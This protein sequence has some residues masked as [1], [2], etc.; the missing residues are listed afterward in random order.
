MRLQ[1]LANHFSEPWDVVARFLGSLGSQVAVD[2]DDV[3]VIICTDGADHELPRETLSS[4]GIPVRYEVLE[5]AGV[6]RTRNALMDMSSAD[7]VM[8]CD[9]DDCMHSTLGL[10]RMMKAM[11][12]VGTDII[13]A[14]YDVESHDDGV[15][16]YRTERRDTTHVFSKAFRRSYLVENGIRFPDEMP[17]SGDMYFLWLAF[18]LG[19]T[20]AWIGD[21]FYVWKDNPDSI[22]RRSPWH[23]VESYG[24]LLRNYQLLHDE[25]GR[26]GRSDL[27][28]T[29]VAAVFAMMY[30]HAHDDAYQ[31]GPEGSVAAMREAMR[32]FATAHRDEYDELTTEEKARALSSRRG[33][34]RLGMPDVAR[35]DEWVVETC[36]R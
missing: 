10:Y 3:E 8:F 26:R 31:S 24:M 21:S 28:S 22:T 2:W 16:S 23:R 6:C 1:I 17:F 12:D 33:P 27:Q 29:L 7:Y 32:S 25:L 35:L 5:H 11:D 14:P 18:N 4:F 36:E 13:A 34:T 9:I 20:L 30:S 15:A 19:P